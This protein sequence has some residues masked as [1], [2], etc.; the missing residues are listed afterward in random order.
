MASSAWGLLLP[1]AGMPSLTLSDLAQMRVESIS[2]FLVILLL[3]TW[4]LKGLWNGL[5]RDF[6]RLPRLTYR[7]SLS[8]V[9]LWGTAFVL[10]LSMI[11]GARELM[12]PGAWERDGLTYRLADADTA[13]D[14]ESA[15][16]SSIA[17][18][19]TMLWEQADQGV[20]PDRSALSASDWRSIDVT[21][22]PF[23]Y[24]PGRHVVR[25]GGRAEVVAHE[26]EM[27]PSPRLA[28]FSDGTI[29]PATDEE[30]AMEGS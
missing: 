26:P 15:R 10:V 16:W 20:L 22:A 6:P 27:F 4:G 21:A 23:Q 7:K 9:V 2:F 13:A 25:P 28:I 30:L 3:A 24:R 1:I 18:L 11:S 29:R 5:A 14:F 19:K 12:T 17:R 8:L